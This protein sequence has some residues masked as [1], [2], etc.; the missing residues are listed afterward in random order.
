M[1][2]A[3][4]HI[5]GIITAL[6]WGFTFVATKT[7]FV[8]FSPIEILI[9]RFIL[10]YAGLWAATRKFLPPRSAREEAYFAAAG[11][12]GITLYYLFENIA[13]T[14][15]TAVNVGIVTAVAPMFTAIVA[16]IFGTDGKLSKSFFVGFAFSMAGIVVI[17]LADGDGLGGGDL[18]GD[19]CAL[20][21]A[22][23]WS[24]YSNIVRHIGS[25]GYSDAVCTRRVFFY[26]LLFMIPAAIYFGVDLSPSRSFT[27]YD[28][29]SLLFLGLGGSGLCFATWGLAVNTLGPVKTSAYI[30]A[31]PIVNATAAMFVLGERITPQIVVGIVL[32]A[33]GL[34]I[35]ETSGRSKHPKVST[36]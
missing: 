33:V 35:Q 30:Y 28:V 15:T 2:T 10:G 25:F 26:G 12:C 18:T 17:S 19:M 1:S 4:G 13:L 11:L 16:R 6:I 34:V 27:S 23:V 24:F 3:A 21:A 36:E 29:A 20:C 7:L 5:A 8:S 9:V 32:T 31:V 14:L 22:I